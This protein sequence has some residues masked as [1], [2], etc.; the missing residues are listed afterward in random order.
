MTKPVRLERNLGGT[1][2]KSGLSKR[3]ACCVERSKNRHRAVGVLGGRLAGRWLLAAGRFASPISAAN[4]WTSHVC[5][6]R[7]KPPRRGCLKDF[8]A[9]M[10]EKYMMGGQVRM[11]VAGLFGSWMARTDGDVQGPWGPGGVTEIGRASKILS[12]IL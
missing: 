7:L 10:T 8:A 9:D 5:T 6:C 12:I 2:F 4:S 11:C 3:F 1:H